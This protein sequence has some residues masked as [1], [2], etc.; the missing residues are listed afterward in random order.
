MVVPLYL[1]E[2]SIFRCLDRRE[3]YT[4]VKAVLAGLG[5]GRATN[6]PKAGFGFDCGGHHQHVGSVSGHVAGDGVAGLKWFTVADRNPEKGLPRVPATIIVTDAKTGLLNGVLDG[7]KL[8][9]VRTAAMAVAATEICFRDA[10]RNAAVIGAGAIG[11]E[12]INFLCATRQIENV[13]VSSFSHSSALS[14][15]EAAGR[16]VKGKV[17][18]HPMPGPQEAVRDADVIIMATGLSEDTDVVRAEWLK[19]DAFICTLGT[20]REVDLD[21]L[22]SATIVVD[23]EDGVRLRK[24]DFREGGVAR[25]RVAASLADVVG[26]R[27][28]LRRRSGRV[29]LVLIGMGALD[30]A[31]AASTLRKAREMGEGLMLRSAAQDNG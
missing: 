4:V 18:L 31:L 27:V 16:L 21:L 2:G 23:D 9:A 7:T 15:C 11:R 22:A 20:H 5:H 30:V 1:D 28:D 29:N 19:E 6:G 24:K 14:A 10:I 3:T 25:A 17:K 12:V 26:G 13:Y 8:T